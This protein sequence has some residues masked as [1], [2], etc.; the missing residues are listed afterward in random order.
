[1]VY[2]ASTCL[3]IAS[4]GEGFGLPLIEAAQ[5]GLPILAR[6]IPVFREVAGDHATYFSGSEVMNLATAIEEWLDR[7][8]AGNVPSSATMPWQTWAESAEKILTCIGAVTAFN[9]VH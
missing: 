9:G 6:D 5:H 4:E 8:H 2:G 3:I 7:Y 1:M